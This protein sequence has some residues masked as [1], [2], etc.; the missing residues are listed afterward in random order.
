MNN[1]ARITDKR[2]KSYYSRLPQLG[3][4]CGLHHSMMVR[5][6]EKGTR[7]KLRG[8]QVVVWVD[9]EDLFFSSEDRGWGRSRSWSSWE[10]SGNGEYVMV[11]LEIIFPEQYG[12]CLQFADM[13]ANS[14]RVEQ[15]IQGS[16]VSPRA[17]TGQ[18]HLDALLWIAS[19]RN[20]GF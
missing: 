15:L 5:W 19:C 3:E 12:G 2:Q 11:P 16:D 8:R 10:A 20:R 17:L 9:G 14:Q 7:R 6:V 13:V 1:K 18:A 4:K